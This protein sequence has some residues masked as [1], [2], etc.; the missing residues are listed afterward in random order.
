MGARELKKAESTKETC[1]ET[2][3]AALKTNPRVR[4]EK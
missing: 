2:D 1:S 4:L 3:E